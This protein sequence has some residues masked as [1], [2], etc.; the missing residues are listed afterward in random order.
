MGAGMTTGAVDEA[1]TGAK[2]G[3]ALRPLRH[4][5][6]RLLW[7][8]QLT[9]QV[10]D[11]IAFVALTGLVW[12]LTGA[13]RWVAALRATPAAPILLLGPLAGVFAGRWDRRGTMLV[14]DLVRAGLM[15]ALA[16]SGVLAAAFGFSQLAAILALSLVFELA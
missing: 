6:F 3:G 2:K 13:G 12:E 14:V 9:S 4:R 8:G 7:L 1:T 16:F 15:G 5:S 11:W 10:G